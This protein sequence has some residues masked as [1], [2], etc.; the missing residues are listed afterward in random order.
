MH[1]S[2]MTRRVE[3]D[4]ANEVIDLYV[5]FVMVISPSSLVIFVSI[6]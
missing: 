3:H 2:T 4:D 1:V 6:V 5:Q